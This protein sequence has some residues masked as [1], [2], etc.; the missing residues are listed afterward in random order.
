MQE[1]GLH[2]AKVGTETRSFFPIC[3]ILDFVC[4]QSHLRKTHGDTLVT[5]HGISLKC[6]CKYPRTR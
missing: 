6:I 5:C 2:I 4:Y 1:E 3:M